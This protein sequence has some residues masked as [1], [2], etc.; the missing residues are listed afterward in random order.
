MDSIRN[1]LPNGGETETARLERSVAAAL[2]LIAAAQDERKAPPV[3]AARRNLAAAH[4]LKRLRRQQERIQERRQ[5]S[6]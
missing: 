3:Q 4:G 6:A 2:D 1:G 5:I